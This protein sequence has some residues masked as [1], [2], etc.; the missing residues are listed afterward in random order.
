MSNY[1]MLILCLV[2]SNTSDTGELPNMMR[3]KYFKTRNSADKY[4][5]I[6]LYSGN[7]PP[8]V[9]FHYVSDTQI[10]VTSLTE[11]RGFNIYGVK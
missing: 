4:V 11:N 7:N 9:M 8:S 1:K 5:Y 3:Y 10:S 2:S 6:S